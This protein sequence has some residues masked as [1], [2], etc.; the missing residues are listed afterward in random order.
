MKPVVLNTTD[1]FMRVVR[2]P[3]GGLAGF[4]LRVDADCC[5]VERTA[6]SDSGRTWSERQV[7]LRISDEPDKWGLP[8]ALAD[9]DGSVHLFLLKY[10][11]GNPYDHQAGEADKAKPRELSQQTCI[12]IWHSKCQ[13]ASEEF[14]PPHCVWMGYTGALNSVVQ[15]RNGRILLPFSYRVDKDWRNRGGEQEDFT[16][17]GYFRS[18]VL[19]SDDHGETWHQSPA[20]L[21]V[22]VPDISYAYGAVE[23]VAVELGDGRIWMLIRTQMGRF[24]ESFSGDGIEWSEPR[25]TRLISSDS[26]AGLV[27]LLD[28]RIVLLWNACL[29]FPYAYGGRHVLHAAVSADDGR[30]WQGF[31][32]AYRDPRNAQPPPTSGDHG[33]AY[34][35]PTATDDGKVIFFS[36]QG[37]GRRALVLLDPDWLCET[38]QPDGFSDGLDDWSVFGTTGIRL[39]ARPD[40]P[41]RSVLRISN[42]DGKMPAAAV[43]NFPLAERG[44]LSVRLQVPEGSAGAMV[45]LTDHFS[46]PFDPEDDLHSLFNLKIAR[47]NGVPEDDDSASGRWRTLDLAWDCARRECQVSIDGREKCTRPQLKDSLGP[48]YL[49]LRAP[50]A[51]RPDPVGFLVESVRYSKGHASD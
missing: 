13:E 42:P 16:Y 48:C 21:K 50:E 11:Q 46:V 38:E 2:P 26:P 41:D 7:V 24:Y 14:S 4:S 36:G 49:R 12:D 29:R 30:T 19:Y 43:R 51:L 31:R 17:W 3:G 47:D 28:N 15:M 23:P 6:S 45:I 5:V 22:P 1:L 34:P 40:S 39:E 10:R 8:E 27:R 18:T 33:T 9:A 44:R 35:F 37:E 20:P 25:A 32:E